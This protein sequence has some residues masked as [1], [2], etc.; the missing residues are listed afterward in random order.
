M[1]GGRPILVRDISASL[2]LSERVVSGQLKHLEDGG[3]LIKAS[4]GRGDRFLIQIWPPDEGVKG[5]TA[6]AFLHLLGGA[7]YRN[8]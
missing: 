4:T 7:V 8:G 3:Y 5:S 6:T 2:G 1:R